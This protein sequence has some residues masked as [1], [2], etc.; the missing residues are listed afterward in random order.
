MG[1]PKLGLRTLAR[2]TVQCHQPPKNRGPSVITDE[3]LWVIRFEWN[4]SESRSHVRFVIDL[5]SA[6]CY[7]VINLEHLSSAAVI[8]GGRSLAEMVRVNHC[9]V[10]IRG[11]RC[12][13]V[14]V[15]GYRCLA[16]V[17]IDRWK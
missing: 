15:C 3:P 11:Y 12:L 13:V 14:E 5:V 16:E 9:L 8:C 17:A 7:G 6:T 1:M 2:E 4:H 10:A